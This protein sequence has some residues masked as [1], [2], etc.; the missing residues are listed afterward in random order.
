MNCHDSLIFLF[1]PTVNLISDGHKRLQDLT[2]ECMPQIILVVVN[3][4][5]FVSWVSRCTSVVSSVN[6]NK[7]LCFKKK[8]EKEKK[9][10]NHRRY[11][12]MYILSRY[13]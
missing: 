11:T 13:S 2:G 1:L 9:A 7:K 4:A 12:V 6:H 10:S 3:C 5:I 8:K